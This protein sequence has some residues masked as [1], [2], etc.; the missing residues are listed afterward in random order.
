[1]ETILRGT[2]TQYSREGG[3]L[4][5]ALVSFDPDDDPVIVEHHEPIG[6]TSSVP[7]G[8]TAEALV[9]TGHGNY[10]N[11]FCSQITDRGVNRP[12][13]SDGGASIYWTADPRHYIKIA[14]DASFTA[15]RHSF[16]ATAGYSFENNGQELLT[17]LVDI[18]DAISQGSKAGDIPVTCPPLP[19][20]V[21]RLRTFLLKPD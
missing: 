12:D 13:T 21:E 17:L 8:M 5:T 4:A 20:L 11:L 19:L 2:I 6:F 16:T 10:D 9:S 18:V 7:P 15:E 3:G 14:R 1:M